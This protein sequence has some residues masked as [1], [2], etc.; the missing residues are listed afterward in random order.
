M[1]TEATHRKKLIEVD[2][3]LDDI[4]FYSAREKSIR[5]GHPSTLHQWWA[6][7]P[8]AACR[9]VV[10][11]SMVDDPS[12]CPD[13]FPT[14]QEQIDERNRLH[15][16]ITQLVKWQ[17]T[18]ETKLA[19]RRLLDTARY[20]IARSV[21]RYRK[22]APPTE[23][24]DVLRYLAQK[25][26]PVYDPF[27][28]GG[29]IPLEAQRLG[30][31]AVGSD[32]NPVAVLITKALVELPP[33]FAGQR[34]I[35]PDADPLDATAT[36]SKTRKTGRWTGTAG[37]ADDIR[38]YGKWI[39][40]EAFQKIG[41]LYPKI[42]TPDGVD[43]TVIAWLWARTVR[44]PNPV[45]N[46]P[47]PLMTTFNLSTK[48]KN[49]HWTKPMLDLKLK[50]LSFSVQDNDDGVP[51]HATAGGNGSTCVS[52]GT[53]VP[54][55]YIREQ[56][57]DSNMTE[58]MTGIVAEAPG[59][60][61]FLSPTDEHIEI[62]H[63]Y[64]P[65]WQPIGDLPT[66]A[67]S[68]SVQ[69][70]G[71]TKWR[72]LFTERQLTAL[73]AFSGLLPEA[74]QKMIEDGASAE[75]ADALCTYLALAVGRA[76]NGS[77]SFARWQNSGEFVASVFTNQGIPMIWDF[78]EVNLFSDSTQ[79]WTGQIEW[80]A[81]VVQRLPSNT[82][83][84]TAYQADAAKTSYGNYGP[85]IATD[86]PYYGQVH[87]ADSSDYFYVW[88]RPLLRDIYP[89]LFSGIQVPKNEEIIASQFRFDNPRERFET[90]LS[91]SLKHMGAGCSPEFPSS[92]FYAYRQQEEE[93]EGRVSTGWDTMLSAL[94]SAGFQIIGT[95]PMRTERP[96]RTNARGVNAL[97]SSVVLVCRPRED[98]A[99]MATRRQFLD[100]L[101]KE[102]PQAL[103]NL[104][105]EGHIAPVDLAQAA[106]GPGMQIYSRYARVETIAGE[107]VS[108]RDA[109]AAINR[110]IAEYDEQQQG[111]LDSET[112]FCLGWLKQYGYTEGPYSQAE[113]L[114]RAMNVAVDDLRDHDKLLT[115]SAGTVR[116]LRTDA[117]GPQRGVRLEGITAW[118]GCYRMV[119]HLDTTHEDGGGTDG[120][121]A[122]ARTMGSD[123]EMVERLARILYN[124]YDR[125]GDSR[126]SVTFNNL[127][128]EWP[129]IIAKAQT[130]DQARLV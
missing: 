32:L 129:R 116:L 109:L 41:H 91:Q 38:H 81:R 44:C 74:R 56:A 87:F 83:G 46:M 105:R 121:A 53:T 12:S 40:K 85:V 128:T 2:L 59:K 20:E 127:V 108:V 65:S 104:T 70:Y 21:A 117:Y 130:P 82:N 55:S 27:S 123:A 49:Q 34:P 11:A 48:E 92:I 94:I 6:R 90:L 42:S 84:G 23:P 103:N 99:P 107:R 17:N 10:F 7:R 80:I 98:S 50:T 126:S 67:R 72:D 111:D 115:A 43:A 60:R 16:I 110:V 52:C 57:R 68:I 118:E 66:R 35:N 88:L 54:I 28:G 78:A 51:H 100:A 113:N 25:G 114:A 14:E 45:C 37:L 124:H 75:Y 47:T 13:E 79:N 64:H 24:A 19:N 39:R 18:D 93:H 31:K 8:L 112:R 5:H 97:A 29:S 62:A 61:I 63:R 77:S 71:F 125:E 120:A 4:N 86:P 119:Y 96:G 30:L 9:A 33:K 26:P 3:P 58:T 106:I 101:E 1:T 69:G 15:A 102:L 36:R 22:E 73:A 89:E 76:V 122:V 95:W